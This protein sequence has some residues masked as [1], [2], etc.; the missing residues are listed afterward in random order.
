MMF[1]E[2]SEEGLRQVLF[3]CFNMAIRVLVF[4][5]Y[6]TEFVTFISLSF[7]SKLYLLLTRF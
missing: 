7:S 1:E 5:G 2:A 6:Q 3:W 4:F